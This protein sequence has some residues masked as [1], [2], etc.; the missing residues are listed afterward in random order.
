MYR[1]TNNS[2]QTKSVTRAWHG[3]GNA[4]I[5]R[6][7]RKKQKKKIDRFGRF[8]SDDLRVMGPP[9][10]LCATKRGPA[11]IPTHM[12]ISDLDWHRHGDLLENCACAFS[13]HFFVRNFGLRKTQSL[14][15][16]CAI[17]A[18]FFSRRPAQ[19]NLRRNPGLRNLGP[20]A[21]RAFC[22]CV[23]AAEC[24]TGL[25]HRRTGL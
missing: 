9:R 11:D 24:L 22:G 16:S 21:V 2:T 20:R 7:K 5:Q 12:D 18:R 15:G 6:G 8:R 10:F 13:A 17:S 23:C 4:Q 19:K 3:G 1:L 25:S 14:R